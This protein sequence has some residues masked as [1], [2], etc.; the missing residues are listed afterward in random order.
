MTPIHGYYVTYVGGITPYIASRDPVISTGSTG[1][2]SRRY[3]DTGVI[4]SFSFLFFSYLRRISSADP[5]ATFL[6]NTPI[7][8]TNMNVTLYNPII[9]DHYTFSKAH[10]KSYNENQFATYVK[11][12]VRN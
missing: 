1:S 12:L 5:N 8:P 10:A 7:I 6:G 11:I 2:Y 3:T 4:F 9:V